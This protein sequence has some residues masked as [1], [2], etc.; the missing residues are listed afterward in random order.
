MAHVGY[1]LPYETL[2]NPRYLPIQDDS[3]LLAAAAAN[4]VTTR[5]LKRITKEYSDDEKS[6]MFSG[7]AK[8]VYRLVPLHRGNDGLDDTGSAGVPRPSRDSD[9]QGYALP[10]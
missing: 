5:R 8:S 1:S 9:A 3:P 10:Q 7:V 4:T 2:V 6:L